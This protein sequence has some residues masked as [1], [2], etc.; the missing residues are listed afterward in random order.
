MIVGA[1]DGHNGKIII[2]GL[3]EDDVKTMRKGLT[4]TKEGHPAYGFSSL[5]VFM[6]KTDKEMIETLNLDKNCL[7]RDDRFPNAGQG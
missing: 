5:V 6:G 1:G 3:T 2:I 4:K 7:R